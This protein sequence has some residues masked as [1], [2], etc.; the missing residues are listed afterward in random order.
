VKYVLA[1]AGSDSFGGAGI[2]ADIKTITGLGG[3][4]LTAIT[5]VTA[6]NSIG[7]SAIYKIPAKFL[8]LQIETILEDIVPD[9]VKTGMLYTGAAIK[10]VARAIEKHGI[11]NLVIDPVVKAST[12]R[13][14]MEEGALEALREFL[15]PMARVV[16]PNMDEAGILSGGKVRTVRDMEE[17][18]RII[19][20][21][22][23]DVVVTGGHLDGTCVDVFFDGRE[24]HHFPGSKIP[25][26]HT[27]GSGC[28]FSS[29]L[30]TYLAGDPV[31]RHA[32][33]GAHYFTRMGIEGSYPCGRGAGPLR[34]R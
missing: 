29:A 5:A 32:V 7:I 6:Q 13:D 28:V 31:V 11:P 22:G 25:T 4:A 30:A 15:L 26:P 21:C 19:K 34:L 14:L 12:G 20:S 3:H 1:I 18:A 17:A 9:A 16:T 33:E 27:H 2:Q 10:V 23:P 8:S 24:F